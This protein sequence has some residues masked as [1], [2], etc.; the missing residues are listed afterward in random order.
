V[1][2]TQ[3]EGARRSGS[4]R[5]RGVAWLVGGLLVV[6]VLLPGWEGRL[7]PIAHDDVFEVVRRAEGVRA[8]P[9]RGAGDEDRWHANYV[10]RWEA[11]TLGTLVPDAVL[12]RL[13]PPDFAAFLP[14]GSRHATTYYRVEGSTHWP[15]WWPGGGIDFDAR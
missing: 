2:V 14:A 10:D 9:V 11:E 1:A 6:L 12:A 4:T 13:S 15:W 7:V 8:V 3:L 5:L